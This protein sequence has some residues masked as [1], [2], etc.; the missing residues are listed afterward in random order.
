M[1]WALANDQDHYLSRVNAFVALAPVANM[2]HVDFSLKVGVKLK[3]VAEYI[4]EKNHFYSLFNPEE[5]DLSILGKGL[6]CALVQ[7]ADAHQPRQHRVV[8]VGQTQALC[9]LRRHLV[10]V[11]RLDAIHQRTAHLLC[12]HH[13][14]NV[15]AFLAPLRGT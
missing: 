13:R 3:G 14:V 9:H 8:R 1:F 10:D 15:E 11:F 6:G 5:M 4:A 7:V 12:H 2:A